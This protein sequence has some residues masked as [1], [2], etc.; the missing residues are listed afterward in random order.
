MNEPS[1][2]VAKSIPGESIGGLGRR[3]K[4]T[5]AMRSRA[6]L[7]ERESERFGKEAAEW[8]QLADILD[9]IEKEARREDGQESGPHIGVGSPAENLL[10]KLANNRQERF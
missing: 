5:D 3:Q 2:M 1:D 7:L 10:W 8:R 6:E 9:T 4:A